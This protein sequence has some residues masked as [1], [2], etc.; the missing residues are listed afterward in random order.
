MRSLFVLFV[1]AVLLCGSGMAMFGQ[2]QNSPK[3]DLKNAGHSSKQAAKST[4]KAVKKGTKKAVHAGAKKTRQGADKVE[5]KT[6][7]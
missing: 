1:S 7:Q 5:G 6:K 4:G 2:D 3:Q